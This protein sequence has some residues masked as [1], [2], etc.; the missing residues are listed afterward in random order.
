MATSS[1][2]V[3]LIINQVRLHKSDGSLYFMAERLAWQDNNKDHFSISHHYRD[4]KREI[5]TSV[6]A[7]SV[8]R[9]L[10]KIIIFFIIYINNDQKFVEVFKQISWTRFIEILLF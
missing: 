1:E 3:L 5:L 4:I 2:E 8:T 6:V 7:E 9:P 10:Q